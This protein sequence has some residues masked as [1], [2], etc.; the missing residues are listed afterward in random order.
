M[1]RKSGKLTRWR[2]VVEIPLLTFGFLMTTIPNGVFFFRRKTFWLLSST[3]NNTTDSILRF[4]SFRKKKTSK[5][6]Q[7]L[8]WISRAIQNTPPKNGRRI[9]IRRPEKGPRLYH[10]S[11]TEKPRW[12]SRHFFFRS[13][14]SGVS[15]IF[16]SETLGFFKMS[17]A[18]LFLEGLLADASSWFS[19]V[20][21]SKEFNPVKTYFLKHPPT[22]LG[23]DL[24]WKPT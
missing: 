15:V 16:V 7:W 2:L 13:Y 10:F 22:W 19:R 18:C 3:W 1:V 9:R 23:L 11:K 6:T 20:V 24:S 12:V 21:F 14:F 5:K 17:V 8:W 4:F